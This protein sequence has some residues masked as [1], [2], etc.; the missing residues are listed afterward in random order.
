MATYK[1]DASHSEATFKVKHLMI[2]NV[3]G[4]FSKF[5]ATL[6]ADKEDFTDAKVTFEADTNSISTNNEQRDGHLKADDF[7][8]VEKFPK[9]TF[10]STSITKKNEEDYIVTGNLTIRDVTKPVTLDVTYNGS[11]IDPWGQTKIGFEINGKINR[12]DFGLVWNAVTETGGFLLNDD[13]KLHVQVQFIK[14]A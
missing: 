9:L 8:S 6:T 12:K 4:S 3:T 7:F 14:Q 2:S 5:D 1:F 11:T 13:V 10:E